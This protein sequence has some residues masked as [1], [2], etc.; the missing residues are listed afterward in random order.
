M[1]AQLHGMFFLAESPWPAVSGE[2]A[3]LTELT[4][5]RRNLFQVTGNVTLPRTTR[6]VMNEHGEQLPI[7]SQELVISATESVEQNSVK[8]ISV[9]W[10]TPASGAPA[11]TEDKAEKEPTTVALDL[12]NGQD[13]DGDY[14][15]LPFAWKRLQFRIATA[16]N[17]RRKELQQHFVVHLQVIATLEDGSK[18]PLCEIHSGPI[19]VRG[20]SPR[21]FQSRNDLP[22]GTSSGGGR[23][24]LH[25]NHGNGSNSSLPSQPVRTPSGDSVNIKLEPPRSAPI[26]ITKMH[27]P[28]PYE[29]SIDMGQLSPAFFD[30][31]MPQANLGAI[32]A[33]QVP[34]AYPLGPLDPS[35]PHSTMYAQ[36]TPDLSRTAMFNSHQASGQSHHGRH[37]SH[38]NISFQ[39][40]ANIP[41]LQP[42]P[43]KSSRTRAP[44]SLSLTDDSDTKPTIQSTPA[45]ASMSPF[46]DSQPPPRKVARLSAT[47]TISSALLS[48]SQASATPA[49]SRTTPAPQGSPRKSPPANPNFTVPVSG[50]NFDADSADLLYE[51]FPLGLD[52]WMPPVD[53]VYRPHVV[54]HTNLPA[55]PKSLGGFSS[56]FAVGGT[57]LAGLSGISSRLDADGSPAARRTSKRYL[58]EE[59]ISA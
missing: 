7:A 1:S 34:S 3:P 18:V 27:I 24:S 35:P 44:I 22:I 42:P 49:E 38:Q 25:T 17:G 59:G 56:G 2:V 4:C 55:D 26:D 39:P 43:S 52:D 29:A 57:G 41:Q 13:I 46:A 31:Q 10:K 53:A 50:T 14:I 21:N 23:R 40:F 8:I 6:Y 48:P 9:P 32:G 33:T 28:S 36:S 54:H 30:W 45:R 11:S 58:S 51:Y 37:H 16:N 5:Y 19:I 47:P 20:R 12:M 15:S